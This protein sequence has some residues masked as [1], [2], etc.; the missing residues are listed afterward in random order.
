MREALTIFVPMDTLRDYLHA[1]DAAAMIVGLTAAAAQEQSPRARVRNLAS[2]RPT[3]I[4]E[5]A[6]VVLQVARRPVRVAAG[7]GASATHQVRDLRV[8][9]SFSDEAMHVPVTPLPAGVK[10]VY[11]HTLQLLRRLATPESRRAPALS[12]RDG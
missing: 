11:D 2:R 9:S 7:R 4:A 6:R 8:G 5:L 12:G 1:R 3:S 10:E